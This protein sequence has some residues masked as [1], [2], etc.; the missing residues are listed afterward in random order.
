M[1]RDMYKRLRPVFLAL[2][3]AMGALAMFIWLAIPVKAI[4]TDGVLAAESVLDSSSKAVTPAFAQPGEVLTFSIVLDNRDVAS[5]TT[6]LVTDPLHPLLSYVL[7]SAHPA[8]NGMG[9]LISGTGGITWTVVISPA[10]AVTLTFQAQV[11]GSATDGTVITNTATI[12]SGGQAVERSAAVTVDLP[13]NVQ[14]HSPDKGSIVT[15][16]ESLTISGYAWDYGISPPFIVDA[17]VLSVQ[18]AGERSYFVNWTA[19]ISAEYY[20]IQEAD[21]PGFEGATET[22][23]AAPGTSYPVSK[24]VG[25]DGVYYYRVRATH[26]SLE[27][28]RWSDVESVL[29]PWTSS[30]RQ[31]EMLAPVAPRDTFTVQ[32]RIDD[33]P[34]QTAAVTTTTWGGWKWAYDWSPLPEERG[35]QYT[36]QA[37]AVDGAG[38]LSPIDTVTITLD[39]QKYLIYLPIALQRYPPI[40]YPPSLQEIDNA[41]T[42]GN[43]RVIWSYS[44]GDPPIN[45]S[46]FS[47][48]EATDLSFETNV[49]D[50]AQTYTTYRDISGKLPAVYYYRV[51]GNNAYGP[52]EWSNAR[53]VA[54][55]PGTP[56][57]NAIDNPDNSPS[58]TVSWSA[59]RDAE[60]YV[61]QQ[62]TSDSFDDGTVK[63]SGSATSYQA[64]GDSSGTYYYRVKSVHG[65]MSSAWS[66]VVSTQVQAGF[67][68]DFS[69]SGSGWPQ[70]TYRR[71]IDPD[72]DVMTVGYVNGTYRMKILLDTVGLN[73]KR[74]GVVKS[75]FVNTYNNYDIEVNHYFDQATD[76]TV[77][78]TWGKGGLIFGANANYSTIYMVEWHF[79]LGGAQAQ[80]AVYKYTNVVLPTS[81]VW[82]AG[83]EPLREWSSCDGLKGGYDQDNKIRVEVRGNKASV[84]INSVR[85]GG[86]TDSGLASNH[87]VGLM[88]GSWDRTPVESRF[89][90]FRVT[91]K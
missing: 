70:T 40:P 85:L 30:A 57:L 77:D 37:R 55:L 66:N 80:C 67:Y 81:I 87:R 64:S 10:S 4:H 41:D 2:A 13:P 22:F 9:T 31:R 62:A 27:A 68:D 73:N 79:P 33:A 28:S 11:D 12:S 15:E 43:Y 52:G 60:S 35:V 14:I 47:L 53:S 69:G 7:G 51:R 46:T 23:V 32:V 65:T 19:V 49:V 24:D 89:D 29:V 38:N 63:Y 83:G 86:F 42:D 21:N 59:G 50:Y 88:T 3:L 74:M 61:L 90:N 34:W 84:F 18:R 45:A 71:G 54:V 20:L 56:V 17:P 48:Q 36:L 72:G 8:P 39:N 78:P 1:N 5:E 82:L 76:Q 91:P 26:Q 16:E 58:Y 44:V 25:E 75:P 6:A